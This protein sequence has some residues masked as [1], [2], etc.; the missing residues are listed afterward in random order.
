MHEDHYLNQRKDKRKGFDFYKVGL[1]G[2][3]AIIGYFLLTEHQAHVNQ[4]L[5]FLL[6]LACPFMHVF[7]HGGHGH[8]SHHHGEQSKEWS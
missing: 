7:M 2:A 5:P 8:H 4:F 1:W 6:L 3:I